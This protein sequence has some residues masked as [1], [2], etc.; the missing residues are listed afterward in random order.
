MPRKTS[1]KRYSEEFKRMLMEEMRQGKWGSP[2]AAARAYGIGSITVLRWMDDAG[3]THLRQRTVEV[4]TLREVSEL[5]KLRRANRALRDQLL[6]EVLAR[7]EDLAVLEAAG[8][9][10]GFSPAAFREEF[11]NGT[12]CA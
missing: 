9:K 12:L 1:Q 11:K 6:D 10:Y 8:R 5:V 3:M 4:K 7:R 2:R